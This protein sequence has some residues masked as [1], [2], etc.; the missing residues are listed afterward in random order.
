M[1]A[2]NRD[3]TAR[4]I[5]RLRAATIVPK[6]WGREVWYANEDQYAGKILEVKEG[7]S[8]SLQKH[9]FKTE[10]MYLLSGKIWFHLNGLEF[11]FIP[12]ACLT[13]RPGD[14][15]R[16]HALEDSVVLEVSTPHLSDVVRLEDNYGRQ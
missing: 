16:L 15:H 6:P 8:L 14:V 5:G 3:N 1:T 12:G 13:I 7:H 4:N 11:E 9:E 10:T 2:T